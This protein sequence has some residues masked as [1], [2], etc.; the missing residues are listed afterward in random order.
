MPTRCP[1]FTSVQALRGIAALLVVLFHLRIVEARYGEGTPLLPEMLRFADGGVDLFFVI[2]GFIMATITSGAFRGVGA[3]TRF[4]AR[5][6]WRIVPLY[7]FYTTVVVVLMAFAPGI[8]NS[9]Y[10]DQGVVASYLLWPQEQLPLLTVGWTLIHEM[11]F[12]LVVAAVLASGQ[13][14]LLRPALAAWAALVLVAN[15]LPA[16][17]TPWY[18][19]VTN[20]MTL[21]FI[22]GAWLGLCWRKIPAQLGGPLLCAGAAGFAVALPALHLADAEQGPVLRTLVF[23]TASLLVVAGAVL[24]ESRGSF[25]VPAWLKAV[26]DSSYSLYLSHVFVISAT[27]RLWHRSGLA[28]AWWHHAIFLASALGLSVLVGLA[29]W[30]WLERPLYRAAR[31]GYSG[32]ELVTR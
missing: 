28:D 20:A 32:A 16:I 26:G 1:S 13:E 31:R 12:Y 24:Q 9:S 8:A 29:S 30:R 5:R 23:G 7:W 14:R 17:G 3:G 15:M 22:A 6:T 2:S 27:A 10:Q 18:A 25:P 11:Y 21:E 4:M 19:L